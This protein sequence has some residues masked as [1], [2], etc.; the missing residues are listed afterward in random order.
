MRVEDVLD[1]RA[2]IESVSVRASVVQIPELLARHIRAAADD[3]NASDTGVPSRDSTFGI[4]ERELRV[5][6][7]GRDHWRDELSVH[8]GEQLGTAITPWRWIIYRRVRSGDVTTEEMPPRDLASGVHARLRATAILDDSLL[9]DPFELTDSQTAPTLDRPA[10]NVRL[11]RR[12]QIF[13]PGE[14]GIDE[15]LLSIDQAIGVAL[16][17]LGF[18]DGEAAFRLT[19]RELSTSPLGDEAFLRY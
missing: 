17:V 14:L 13:R 7:R 4:L 11:K 1:R 9:Q 18:V 10:W 12:N 3:R 8:S 5:W 19:V 15:Y 6:R 2:R 16:A